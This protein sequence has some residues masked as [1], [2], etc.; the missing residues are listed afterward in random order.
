M[1]LNYE[2]DDLMQEIT[3]ECAYVEKRKCSF[4]DIQSIE[5]IITQT[6]KD[7]L[8]LQLISYPNPLLDSGEF[9]DAFFQRLPLKYLKARW[10]FFKYQSSQEIDQLYKQC[11]V[12]VY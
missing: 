8:T 6:R 3:C 12:L 10:I 11:D 5:K 9:S 1:P 7:A 2:V 4:T